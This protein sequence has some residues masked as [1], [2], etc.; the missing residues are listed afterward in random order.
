MCRGWI[1]ITYLIPT[2]C[3]ASKP[4]LLVGLIWETV[5][6]FILGSDS[7]TYSLIRGF[8]VPKPYH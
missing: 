2:V 4:T 6:V 7:K 3:V 8:P 5:N 1:S